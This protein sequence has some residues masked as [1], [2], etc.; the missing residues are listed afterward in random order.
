MYLTH[1]QSNKTGWVLVYVLVFVVIIQ[2]TALSALSILKYN[3][4]S[5]TTFHRLLGQTHAAEM[6]QTPPETS[7][8]TLDA[9]Q[10]WDNAVFNTEL[11]EKTWGKER[12]FFWRAQLREQPVITTHE[13]SLSVARPYVIVLIDDCQ[14][15]AGA[16]GQVYQNDNIYLERTD[17]EII[18]VPYRDDVATSEH[19]SEGTYFQGNYGNSYYSAPDTNGF[20]GTISCWAYTR[21]YIKDLIE[22]LDMCEVALAST[23]QGLIVPFT[24]DL[25][26]LLSIL[27]TLHPTALT[28]PVSEALVQLLDDFPGECPTGKHII[29]ATSGIAIDDGNLPGWLQDFDNDTNVQDCFVEG[30]GSHCLDDVAAYASTLDIKV[31]VAGPDTT[32]LNDVAQKGGGSYMPLKQSILTIQDYVCQERSLMQNTRRFLTNKNVYFDPGWLSKTSATCYQAGPYDP[33]HLAVLPFSAI[34]G[35]ATSQFTSGSSLFCSTSQNCLVSIDMSSNSLDWI[36]HGIGG[37]I[38]K[39]KDMIVAGPNLYGYVHALSEEPDIVWRQPGD[40]FVS[41]MS[42]VYISRENTITS[43][44]LNSGMF[45]TETSTASDISALRYDP[46][47][48]LLLAATDSGTVYIF[49]QALDLQDILV[50]NSVEAICDIH[51][52]SRLKHLNIIVCSSNSVMCTT[53]SEFLW[54]ED[55]DNGSFLNAVVIDF[56]VYITTWKKTGGCEGLDTGRSYLTVIDAVSGEKLKETMLLTGR[57]FGPV[58]DLQQKEIEY[59][60]WDMNVYEEDISELE[61]IS[62]CPL[63]SMRIHSDQ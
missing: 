36:I 55:L 40:F 57:A 48:G 45:L 34:H 51:T 15:M 39:R 59:T 53:P 25:A 46:C 56:K 44:A 6:K 1:S 30:A 41:S 31:H 10:G 24:H 61:G 5:G 28:S 13:P 16:C 12:S 49:N 33:F 43:L 21:S 22:G 37:K 19:S 27:E 7:L 23:S 9:P 50:T 54:S 32:F 47:H 58:I 38:I 26:S 3:M 63:G 29:V 4:K 20:G 18:P 35:P 60:A 17:G 8:K 14:N 11:L 62:Y 52:F 42:S 2:T